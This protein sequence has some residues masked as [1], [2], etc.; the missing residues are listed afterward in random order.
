ML[1]EGDILA[2][3]V[4]AKTLE[5]IGNSNSSKIFYDGE[6]TKEIV[7]EIN[8]EGGIFEVDDLKSYKADD[9]QPLVASLGHMDGSKLFSVP[10]PAGGGAVMSQAL[11]ILSGEFRSSSKTSSSGRVSKYRDKHK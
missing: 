8:A 9:K 11:Q 3:P 5:M 7:K 10:P 6:F 1:V 4:Y 2:R